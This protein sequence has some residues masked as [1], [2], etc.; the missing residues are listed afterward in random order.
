MMDRF[1]AVLG[2]LAGLTHIVAFVLYNLGTFQGK[3]KPTVATW[4]LWVGLSTVN[5]ITYALMTEDWQKAALPVASTVA[6]VATFCF[7]ASIGKFGR[8]NATGWTIVAMGLISIIVWLVFRKAMYGNLLLQVAIAY[9]FIPTYDTVLKD[10]GAE[11]PLPWAV[12][13]GAY[14]LTFLVVLLRWRG[15][16]QD[17]AYPVNCLVLHGGIGLL[18]LR[19]TSPIRSQRDT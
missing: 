14:I 16:Y 2:L 11:K 7:V 12:W 17:L 19:K 4:T 1:T 8:L 13:S 5:C 6:C 10:A 9:S 3:I 18:T 15:Q